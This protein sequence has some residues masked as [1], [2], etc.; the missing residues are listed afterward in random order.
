MAK[1]PQ[2]MKVLLSWNVFCGSVSYLI[3]QC[4]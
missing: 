4:C 1:T 3:P 2:E